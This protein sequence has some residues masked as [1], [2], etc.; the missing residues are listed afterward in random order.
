MNKGSRRLFVIV[1]LLIFVIALAII[2]S[3]SL[4]NEVATSADAEK[5]SYEGKIPPVIVN[6]E[7]LNEDGKAVPM[8]QGFKKPSQNSILKVRLTGDATKLEVFACPTGTDGYMLQKIEAV[9]YDVNRD[10]SFEILLTLEE[11]FMGRVW[12]LAYNDNVALRSEE[13]NII[14]Q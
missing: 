6:M 7:L 13:M 8:D 1:G 2:C 4:A 14:V 9:E 3:L 12:V 11:S 10:G 5:N